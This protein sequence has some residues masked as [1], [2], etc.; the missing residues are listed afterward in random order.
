MKTI[1][2]FFKRNFPLCWHGVLNRHATILHDASF[3]DR[4]FYR[5]P[6]HD[7]GKQVILFL[8]LVSLCNDTRMFKSFPF[9]ESGDPEI[10]YFY[11]HV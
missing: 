4:N 11:R 9:N 8:A 3:V 2:Q 10:I 6:T 1:K 5:I 7:T